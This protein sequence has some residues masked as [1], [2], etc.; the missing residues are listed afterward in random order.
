MIV[1]PERAQ[2]FSDVAARS[3]KR[4]EA[5]QYVGIT[6]VVEQAGVEKVAREPIAF[7]RS[8][9]IVKMGGGLRDAK[10]YV[11]GRQVVESSY[12]QRLAVTCVKS[13]S[14]KDSIETPYRVHGQIPMEAVLSLTLM[15]LKEL[16]WCEF[17]PPLVY[18]DSGFP[19]YRSGLGCG[20]QRGDWLRDLRNRKR[21]YERGRRRTCR[22][23]AAVPSSATLVESVS[24]EASFG[25]QIACARQ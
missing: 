7:G 14:G 4:V 1:I 5:R 23:A 21:L 24:A 3:R 11:I 2:R 25:H 16:L 8:V 22:A 9:A 17:V 18:A 19:G 10:T 12:E 6:L 20:V 15:N 13:W